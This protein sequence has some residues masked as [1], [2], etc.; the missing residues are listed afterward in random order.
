M[1][2]K[3]WTRKLDKETPVNLAHDRRKE[4][5]GRYAL[6]DEDLARSLKS[7]WDKAK[8][9]KNWI[10]QAAESKERLIEKV[11][12]SWISLHNQ[13][14]FFRKLADSMPK[15]LQSV[16]DADGAYIDN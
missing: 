1:S 12:Q 14:Q 11:R 8:M 9:V 13:P 15:R 16:I 5:G 2:G 6:S 7:R 4:N 3:T 10:P